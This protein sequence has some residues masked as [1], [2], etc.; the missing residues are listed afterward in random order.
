MRYLP[1]PADPQQQFKK[2]KRMHQEMMCPP[3]RPPERGVWGAAAPRE[4]RKRSVS[5]F[6]PVQCLRCQDWYKQQMARG[7]WKA[8]GRAQRRRGRERGEEGD[9]V[10]KG[11]ERMIFKYIVYIII[12]FLI[13]VYTFIYLHI[14]PN[15]SKYL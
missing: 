9:R 11:E 2:Y 8:G 5:N 6:Y 12:Y 13:L 14:L 3:A 1:G 10:R 15:T 7:R 4:E